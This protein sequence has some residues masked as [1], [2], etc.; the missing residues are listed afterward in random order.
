[1]IKLKF[2]LVVL[3]ITCA[4]A[5]NACQQKRLNEAKSGKAR[6]RGTNLGGWFALESWMATWVW[7]DNGCNRTEY[8]GC[9]MLQKCLDARTKQ[10]M[11]KHWSTFVTENDFAEMSRRGINVV[12]IPIGWWQVSFHRLNSLRFHS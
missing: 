11:M 2:F 8:Q 7:D 3:Y 5:Q 6:W 1:M 12:R 10:V 9:H 4:L